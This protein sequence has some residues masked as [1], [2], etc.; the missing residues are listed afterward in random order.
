M[1]KLNT[2][3][4]PNDILRTIVF[5]RLGRE[6]ASV[7]LGPSVGEDS[8]LIELN[9]RVVAFKSDPITGSVEEVGLLSV[10]VNAND[11]A[12]RGAVPRWFLQCI[13][14]PQGY[15]TADLEAICLQIDK[16][17]K[18]IGVSVVGGHTEVTPGI[19]KPLVIGSMIGLIEDGKYLTTSGSQ[20]GDSLF[21]TK[22]AG[23]EGTAILSSEKA[24]AS[25]FGGDF[26]QTCKGLIRLINVVGECLILRDQNVT[27]IHD[28]TEGGLLGGVWEVAEASC[29]GV[30]LD[31]R[32]VPVLRET[33]L[34]CQ[35]LGLDPFRLI[36][37]GSVVFTIPPEHEEAA[38]AALRMAGIQ[39]TRIGRMLPP[40]EGRSFID[41]SGVMHHLDPPSTDELWRGLH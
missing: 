22:S 32:P 11:I 2:G 12:T 6:D 35:E 34:V 23:I 18:E 27:S 24:I 33:E 29:S 25:K 36:S 30:L 5:G 7:I 37:S 3:K 4:V 15:S 38:E 13:L 28:L 8:A 21:M 14:L 20:P 41:R 9:G 19:S 31:L 17:T 10:Y 40:S 1:G 26:V 39:C 16:A